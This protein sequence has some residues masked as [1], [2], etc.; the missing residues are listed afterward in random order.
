MRVADTQDGKVRDIDCESQAFR[1]IDVGSCWT[2]DAGGF[3]RIGWGSIR[4]M[5]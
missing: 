4:F 5:E 3:Q 1:G 2:I